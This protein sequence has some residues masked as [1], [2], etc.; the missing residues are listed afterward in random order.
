[1][2]DGASRRCLDRLSNRLTKTLA[3]ARKLD[4]PEKLAEIG[5]ISPF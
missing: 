5:R 1:L 2:P 3:V 4:A